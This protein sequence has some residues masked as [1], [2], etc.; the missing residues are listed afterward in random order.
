MNVCIAG[1]A[2]R[3]ARALAAVERFLVSFYWD[4]SLAAAAHPAG[5]LPCHRLPQSRHCRQAPTTHPTTAARTRRAD[6]AESG[7]NRLAS[8]ENLN[9][10]WRTRL[11]RRRSDR[12][13]VSGPVEI[14]ARLSEELAPARCGSCTGLILTLHFFEYDHK[15]CLRDHAKDTR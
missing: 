3:I 8:H 9:E 6:G 13:T 1:T 2:A 7:T 15:P 14:R 4:C 11:R 5:Q 12:E 10:L